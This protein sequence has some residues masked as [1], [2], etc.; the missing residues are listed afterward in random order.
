M[1]EGLRTVIGTVP[2]LETGKARST[3]SLEGG[4]YRGGNALG[5]IEDLHFSAA[6]VR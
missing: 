6:S 2:E 5:V 4:S 1:I 3:R